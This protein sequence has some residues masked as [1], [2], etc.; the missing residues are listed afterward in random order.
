MW[1][2]ELNREWVPLFVQVSGDEA[3]INL[4]VLAITCPK[5]AISLLGWLLTS[6][7]LFLWGW[8][9]KNGWALWGGVTAFFVAWAIYVAREDWFK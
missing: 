3:F 8:A 1:R 9:E 4:G 6:V 2:V 7:I 5:A